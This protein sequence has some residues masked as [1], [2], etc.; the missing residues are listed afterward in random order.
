M[1]RLMPRAVL[2]AGLLLFFPALAASNLPGDMGNPAS[3]GATDAAGRANEMADKALYKPVDYPN[4]SIRGPNLIIIPGEIKS[5]NA[6]FTQKI[7]PNNIADFAELEFGRA[8]FGVLERAD[9]GPLLQEFQLAYTLGDPDAAA[10]TLKVGKLKTTQWVVKL[11][12]LKAEQVAT[13]QEGFDGR[14]LG[15]LINIFGS[16]R[17][18]GEAAGTIIGSVKTEEGTGIWIIG[19]RYKI[20][21]AV[22]TEQVATGYTEEKMEVGAKSTSVLGISQGAEGGLTLDGMVQRLVQKLVLDIDVNLKGAA[23]SPEPPQAS[24]TRSLPAAAPDDETTTRAAETLPDPNPDP[25]SE[26]WRM[27]QRANSPLAYRTYLEAFPGGRYQAAAR[28]ALASAGATVRPAASPAVSPSPSGEGEVSTAQP[29][30][31]SPLAPSESGAPLV[32]SMVSTAGEVPGAAAHEKLSDRNVTADS[33]PAPEAAVALPPCPESQ[34]VTSWHDCVGSDRDARGAAI[35]SGAYRNGLRHGQGSLLWSSGE[36]HE[37]QF[38]AGRIEG[39]GTRSWPNGE[40]YQGE[41]KDGRIHGDGTRIWA[42]GEKYIGPFKDGIS[43][44]EGTFIWPS[45][46]QY[47]GQFSDGQI[48]GQGTRTWPNGEKYVG[49][50]KGGMMEGRG[51]YFWTHGEKYV[52]QWSNNMRHGLGIQYDAAGKIIYQGRWAGNNM[53]AD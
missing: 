44:G 35:Y 26:T 24:A 10:R 20:L 3:P 48:E 16:G 6:S 50:F 5:A 39:Q 15:Q 22:T 11:D 30:H 1:S 18:G 28:I 8:N 13:A 36:R 2:Y 29:E 43:D 23:A 41:F 47:T 52:G 33:V 19:M 51:T 27:A 32:R 4:A 53:A 12:I 34:P 46:E 9:L 49:E 25:D 14:A 42:N 21:N 38:V 37:G 31:H 45:G 7:G 17:R 40:K